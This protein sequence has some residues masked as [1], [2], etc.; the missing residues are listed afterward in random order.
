MSV[1]L[2]RMK[3]MCGEIIPMM[4]DGGK[5]EMMQWSNDEWAVMRARSDPM[6]F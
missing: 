4:G 1:G 2:G 6:R 3:L 5:S